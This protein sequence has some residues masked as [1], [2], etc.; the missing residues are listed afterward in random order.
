VQALESGDGSPR[1]VEDYLK[2]AVSDNTTQA[3]S[4]R[5]AASHHGK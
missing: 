5:I 1:R 2:K 3:G 4:S